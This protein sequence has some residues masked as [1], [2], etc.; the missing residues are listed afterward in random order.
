M[1]W[2]ALFLLQEYNARAS[3]MPAVLAARSSK[4]GC[5]VG[6]NEVR[7]HAR[8]VCKVASHLDQ[9]PL[10]LLVLEKT[11]ACTADRARGLL[12]SEPFGLPR[13]RAGSFVT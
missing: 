3:A 2:Q 7:G 9:T 4:F 11:T 5:D 6:L 8:L 13:G 1:A 10:G 12:L